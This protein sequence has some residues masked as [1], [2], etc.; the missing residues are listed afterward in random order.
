MTDKVLTDDEKSALL[1]GVRSGDVEVQSSVG[2]T[3]ASVTP[4]EI[5]PRSR[6][7]KD[8]YPRLQLL[9]Q[10][11]ADRLSKYAEQLL[12]C[13]IRVAPRDILV[14]SYGEFCEQLAGY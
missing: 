12:Q 10:Q 8:S 14:R 6:I 4:F 3:Y 13:E 7:L 5:G 2:P 9:N 1:E 11:V